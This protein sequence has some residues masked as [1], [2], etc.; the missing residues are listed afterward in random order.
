MHM[1]HKQKIIYQYIGKKDKTFKGQAQNVNNQI[2]IFILFSEID[3]IQKV[4]DI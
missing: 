3:E 4:K 2:I 1:I